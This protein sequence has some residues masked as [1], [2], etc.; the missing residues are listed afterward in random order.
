MTGF[1]WGGGE[2]GREGEP[3]ARGGCGAP[4]RKEGRC[5]LQPHAALPD[6]CKLA[7]KTGLW[8]LLR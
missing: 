7:S 1:V 4:G 6:G 8:D 5:P 2:G 3:G